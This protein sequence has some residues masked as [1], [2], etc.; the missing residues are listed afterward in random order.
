MQQ[1]GS[2]YVGLVGKILGDLNVADIEKR[3]DLAGGKPL[4]AKE[5]ELYIAYVQD[6]EALAI[7]GVPE[8]FPFRW[9]DPRTGQIPKTGTAANMPYDPPDATPW[10]LIITRD[11]G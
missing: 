8:G 5:G 10:V 1:E 4:L 11:A 9:V 7:Q 3:W 6:G 2:I